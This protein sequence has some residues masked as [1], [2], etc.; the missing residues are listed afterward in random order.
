MTSSQIFAPGE[1]AIL[2]IDGQGGKAGD[3]VTILN[4]DDQ[5]MNGVGYWFEGSN[6]D[7]EWWVE[8]QYLRK[9]QPPTEDRKLV[10]WDSCPWQPAG[11]TS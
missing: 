5:T 9:K 6:P 3:E 4:F 8:T 10:S 1:V 7:S 11:V 2:L